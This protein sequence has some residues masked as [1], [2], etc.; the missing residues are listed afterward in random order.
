MYLILGIVFP[1][2]IKTVLC[3]IILTNHIEG[4]T[5]KSI[6]KVFTLLFL[7]HHIPKCIVQ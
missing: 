4:F 7:S 2:P 1:T 3:E 6:G 5:F